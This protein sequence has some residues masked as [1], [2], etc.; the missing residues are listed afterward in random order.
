MLDTAVRYAGEIVGQ[1]QFHVIA[2][3]P[4][5]KMS[6][7]SAVTLF[8]DLFRGS[9]TSAAPNRGRRLLRLQRFTASFAE[10]VF[11]GKGGRA[12]GTFHG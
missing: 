3:W 5:G 7:A 6:T 8:I 10:Q 4:V 9:A 2:G 11:F 1:N 12:E